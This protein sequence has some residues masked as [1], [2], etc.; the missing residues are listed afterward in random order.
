[1]KD[2]LKSIT[3]IK[4]VLAK[5]GKCGVTK[6]ADASQSYVKCLNCGRV[7]VI[8]PKNK[9]LTFNTQEAAATAFKLGA[10]PEP[11]RSR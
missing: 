8:Q 3:G 4:Y 5:C 9:I 2:K 6:P 10:K 1:M 7:S 11:L